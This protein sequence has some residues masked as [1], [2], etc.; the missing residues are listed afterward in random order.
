MTVNSVYCKNRYV[1]EYK[2]FHNYLRNTESLALIA[3]V[4]RNSRV[5]MKFTDAVLRRFHSAVFEQNGKLQKINLCA[6]GLSSDVAN[7]SQN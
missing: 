2:V 4:E 7:V 3:H 5:I 1:Y 6:R